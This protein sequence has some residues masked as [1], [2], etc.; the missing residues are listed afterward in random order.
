MKNDEFKKPR[1]SS[2]FRES[3]FVV[4]EQCYGI[5]GTWVYQ[6]YEFINENYFGGRLPWAHIIWGLTEYGA[7][8]AWASTVRDKSRPPI[9]TLHPVLLEQY[10]TADPW[11]IPSECLV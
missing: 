2:D 8:I 9:I 5:K 1:F 11:G 6:C 10:Q 3:C 4:A 7:C